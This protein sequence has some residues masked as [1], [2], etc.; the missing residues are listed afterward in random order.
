MC[1]LVNSLTI[2]PFLAT[3]LVRVWQ[4]AFLEYVILHRNNNYII[5]DLG[6]VRKSW[7]HFL[8]VANVVREHIVFLS[9][10]KHTAADK[11]T[12]EISNDIPKC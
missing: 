2:I 8:L 4:K 12:G 6:I 7:I 3:L 11:H 9:L 1:Q 10:P 5:F